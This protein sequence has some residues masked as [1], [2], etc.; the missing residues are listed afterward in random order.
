LTTADRAI[1]NDPNDVVD[2]LVDAM[3]T[4]DPETAAAMYSED[5]VIVDPLFD[6]VGREAAVEA[7]RA[8][9]DAFHVLSLEVVERIVDGSRIAV[10]WVRRAIHQ[11]EYLGVPPSGREISSW[12][13]VFF[14]T[15]HGYVT[16]DLSTWDS[17]QLLK[18]REQAGTQ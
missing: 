16:R 7:F 17:S 4:N 9:F 18:L 8:W 3:L 1:T 11:G 2:R 14:D 12:N 5:V 10:R 15:R 13:V 6:V